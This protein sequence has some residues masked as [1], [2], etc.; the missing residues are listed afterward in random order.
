LGRCTKHQR[1][2]LHGRQLDGFRL[3]QRAPLPAAE[4]FLRRVEHGFWR[5]VADHHEKC[6][7]RTV[8]GLV[9]SGDG[10]AIDAR[11]RFLCHAGTRVRVIAKQRL[12]EQLVIHE[13]RRRRLRLQPL[14]GR[15]L[16][17]VEL[18]LRKRWI[19]HDIGQHRQHL[20]QRRGETTNLERGGVLAGGGVQ[21]RAHREHLALDLLAR[22]RRGAFLCQIDDK[23]RQSRLVGRIDGKA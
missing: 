23:L 12:P 14:R 5:H 10:V 2:P 6:V 21:A 20:R 17:Q 7:V 9:I 16:Q 11:Q 13:L 19:A 8:V 18:A 15:G 3:R 1:A 22:P 4:R